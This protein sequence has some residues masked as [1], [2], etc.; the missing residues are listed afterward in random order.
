VDSGRSA[1]GEL[2]RKSAIR[3]WLG[4]AEERTR[5]AGGDELTG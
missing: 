1:S 2:I 5:Y 3:L 4:L